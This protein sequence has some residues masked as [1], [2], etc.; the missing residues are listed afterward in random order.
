MEVLNERLGQLKMTYKC[1]KDTIT[2]FWS[3]EFKEE[4]AI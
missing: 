3:G 1:H 4:K 2:M